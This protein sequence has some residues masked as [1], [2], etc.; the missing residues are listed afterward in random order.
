M[1]EKGAAGKGSVGEEVVLDLPQG[2]DCSIAVMADT[3]YPSIWRWN[4][5]ISVV[6]L[7][8][9][10]AMRGLC[11]KWTACGDIASLPVNNVLYCRSSFLVFI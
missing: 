11:H 10:F 6:H 5:V 3:T 2:V 9:A 1:G 4:G 7:T 8:G